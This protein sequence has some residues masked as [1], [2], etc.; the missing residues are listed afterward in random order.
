[1]GPERSADRRCMGILKRLIGRLAFVL[2]GG[3]SLRPLIHR[4]RGVRMGKNVWIAQYVYLD[5]IYPEAITIGEN[6]TIGLRT[7]VFSHFHWGPRRDGAGFKPVTL[8]DNVFVGPHCVILPGVHIGEGAVI[9]AGSVVTRNVPPGVFW[10]RAD[11]G[12]LAAA[13]VPLTSQ[14][15]YEAFMRGLRPLKRTAR[16]PVAA[17]S[18]PKDIET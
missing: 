6:C 5:E 1:M 8:A 15:S 11:D 3:D 13:T 2:P 9:K 7:S 16:E 17:Q 18:R 10:G 4:W 12:P 14:S